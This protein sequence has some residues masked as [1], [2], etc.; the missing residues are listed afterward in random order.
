MP[1]AKI[2]A[3]RWA[4][5]WL[6]ALL[7]ILCAASFAYNAITLNRVRGDFCTWAVAHRQ[8]VL[9][10]PKTTVRV[11]VAADD[12]RLIAQLGC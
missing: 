2:R 7:L 6:T 8:E 1:T 3:A 9:A 11:A 10:A 5:I 12:A 4:L